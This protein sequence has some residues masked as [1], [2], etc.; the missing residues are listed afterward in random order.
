MI[1]ILLKFIS[2][3]N[4]TLLSF[5]PRPNVVSYEENLGPEPAFNASG[6]GSQTVFAAFNAT[7]RG[8]WGF[9]TSSSNNLNRRQGTANG[10]GTGFAGGPANMQPTGTSTTPNNSG[11]AA[12]GSGSGPNSNNNIASVSKTSTST[13]GSGTGPDNHINSSDGGPGP[14]GPAKRQR[15]NQVDDDSYDSFV[16]QVPSLN[17]NAN[18]KT[19][20]R[21]FFSAANSN[22]NNNNNYR[23]P[24][25]PEFQNET[26]EQEALAKERKENLE[27]I[28]QKDAKLS[29][30][31][32]K[33]EIRTGKR[34]METCRKLAKFRSRVLGARFVL[35]PKDPSKCDAMVVVENRKMTYGRQ[36]A[37]NNTFVSNE[38]F[39]AQ[40][41]MTDEDKI[42][43]EDRSSNGTWIDDERIPGKS[44]KVKQCGPGSVITCGGP[45]CD[46]RLELWRNDDPIKLDKWEVESVVLN[47]EKMNMDKRYNCKLL[48]KF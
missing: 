36:L 37:R 10:A 27:R 14:G 16:N 33:E 39:V 30:I 5:G 31:A 46:V 21:N 4:H 20:I 34:L 19:G 38:H 23:N 2:T 1:I 45:K 7:G 25:E 8:Q 17:R 9:G 26:E 43:V 22:N 35:L 40:K 11:A 28:R 48:L 44:T 47:L 6:R 12:E 29:S 13:S 32:H 42:I 15:V 41:S 3:I 24:H 18:Q